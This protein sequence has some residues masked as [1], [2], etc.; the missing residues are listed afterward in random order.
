M[1]IGQGRGVFHRGKNMY[2]EFRAYCPMDECRKLII[3]QAPKKNQYNGL[4]L[5]SHFDP[6]HCLSALWKQ[7]GN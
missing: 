3:L 1:T 4:P 2:P 5:D 7:V 6:M